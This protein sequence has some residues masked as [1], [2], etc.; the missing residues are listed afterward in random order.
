[1][2]GIFLLRNI[3]LLVRVAAAAVPHGMSSPVQSGVVMDHRG[4]SEF[5]GGGVELLLTKAVSQSVNY[6][7]PPRELPG[8][9]IL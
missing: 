5:S 9:Y 1:M 6:T 3:P 4:L 7:H 2:G 8:S